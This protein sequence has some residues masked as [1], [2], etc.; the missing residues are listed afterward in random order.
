MSGGKNEFRYVYCRIYITD[1]QN[2]GNE[3][4]A[5]GVGAGSIISGIILT[6]FTGG[7]SIPMQWVG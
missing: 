6:P 5:A 4:S 2:M 3:H 1:A 7:V